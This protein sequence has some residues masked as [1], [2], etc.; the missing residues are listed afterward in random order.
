MHMG[1]PGSEE[2]VAWS[3]IVD[4]GDERIGTLS[5]LWWMIREKEGE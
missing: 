4:T 1:G 2:V 5:R 3:T